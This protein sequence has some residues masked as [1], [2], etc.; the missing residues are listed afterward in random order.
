MAVGQSSAHAALFIGEAENC[1]PVAHAI[2][3]PGEVEFLPFDGNL[4]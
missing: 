4:V 3:I 1:A 2:T